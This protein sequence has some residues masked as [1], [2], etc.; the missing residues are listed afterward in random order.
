VETN[1]FSRRQLVQSASLLLAGSM[2]T[3]S[4]FGN[5]KEID[6]SD[7]L[8][9]VYI[10]PGAGLK[11]KISRT[12]ITFKLDKTQTGG[13]LGSAEMIIPPGQLGAPPHYH[14]GFDEI[15]IV[16]KGTVHIMVENEVF[17]VKE[18]GWHLRPRGKTHTFWNSGKKAAKVIEL[19]APG[20]HESYMQD[21]SKLFEN[22]ARPHPGDLQKL[23]S[24]YDIVF[25]LDKLDEVIKKYGVNL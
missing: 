2:I 3:P 23:A 19:Y 22:G 25:R 18:G 17:K 15:C 9:A 21:L 11:G 24:K 10:P 8:K 12:D 14:K 6:H 4:L 1:K 7:D 5:A 16:L 20:G 13:N